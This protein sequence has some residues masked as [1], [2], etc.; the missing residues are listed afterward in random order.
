MTSFDQITQHQNCDNI[1][2][3]TLEVV[4]NGTQFGFLQISVQPLWPLISDSKASSVVTRNATCNNHVNSTE[5]EVHQSGGAESTVLPAEYKGEHTQ[6]N[7]PWTATLK[8]IVCSAT[9][10]Y[11]CLESEM[12]D[13][14]SVLESLWLTCKWLC[15]L[16]L[17]LSLTHSF[18]SDLRN[19]WDLLDVWTLPR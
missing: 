2:G 15:G 14:A 9:W 13:Y 10:L 5:T 4:W 17:S 16:S 6:S 19:K 11:D 12:I 18:R 7:S 8:L 3:M 1:V